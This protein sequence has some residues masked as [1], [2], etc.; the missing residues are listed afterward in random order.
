M[1][2]ERSNNLNRFTICTV[3]PIQP[4][5]LTDGYACSTQKHAQ[6]K[7]IRKTVTPYTHT[8]TRHKKQN[9]MWEHI[10]PAPARERKRAMKM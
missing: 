5:E 3:H 1:T 6:D 2:Q 8:H 7:K 9:V 4:N 10:S